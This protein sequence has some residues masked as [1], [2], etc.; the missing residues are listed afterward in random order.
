MG[1][2][3]GHIRVWDLDR[4]HASYLLGET[5]R[6]QGGGV[7]G[8]ADFSTT[9]DLETSGSNVRV[10]RERLGHETRSKAASVPTASRGPVAPISHH[11]VGINA[12]AVVTAPSRFLLSASRDGVVKVWR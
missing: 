3:D 10:L 4:P 5:Q 6:S 2:S 12:L 8:R 11:L 9:Y 7:P 1:S